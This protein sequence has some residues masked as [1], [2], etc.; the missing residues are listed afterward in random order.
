MKT[1]KVLK[2]KEVFPPPVWIMRQA[3][4][5]LPEFQKV[6]KEANGFINM[7]YTPKIAARVTLQPVKRFGFDSAIIFSDILVIP[8][9]L[10]QELKYVEGEGPKL[11][12]MDLDEMVKSFS[13]EKNNLKLLK[14][15]EAIK[16]T[17]R[18]LGNKTSLI[19]FVGAPLTISFFMLDSERKKNYNKLLKNLKKTKQKT[20]KL[21]SLLE[22][23]IA[24]H[25]I[26]QIKAGAQIIQIFDTWADVAKGND[27]KEF[28]IKPIKK[29]SVLIKSACPNTPIIVFPRN[30]GTEYV[31]YMFRT[32]DCIS[33]G[34]DASN[35]TIKQIQEKK[36]IQGNLSPEI[37][38]KG[39]PTLD[40]EIIKI[41]KR[42]AKK[43]FIFNLSHGILPKT[44]VKNVERLLK[45][46]REYKK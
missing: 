35:K 46:I 37:L 23:A 18:K 41:I 29:I 26:K 20:R 31:K 16:E 4:R 39:G 2:K 8:D 19:G 21:F 28:S 44:P 15:Y 13:I 36:I 40:K 3:G 43:P 14:V 5:Y 6:K 30:V 12:K 7:I 32:I 42:F 17:K 22:L 11:K 10:G 34:N 33:V 38:F 1:I 25:A 27:L 45:I 24:K 9:S